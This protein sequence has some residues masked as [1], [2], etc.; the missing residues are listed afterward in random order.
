M[1]VEPDALAYGQVELGF[2]FTKRIL[3]FNDGDAPLNVNVADNRGA[4]AA[5]VSNLAQWPSRESGNSVI[6]P[7]PASGTS[8]RE[9]KMAYRPSTPGAHSIGMRVTGDDPANS[10]QSVSLTGEGIPPI[11]IDSVPVLDR[12]GSMGQFSGPHRKIDALQRAS[13]MFV[14]LPPDLLAHAADASSPAKRPS[15]SPGTKR[16]AGAGRLAQERC[17]RNQKLVGLKV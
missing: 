6:P 10:P 14:H 8:S 2:A 16:C 15:S 1:R 4:D 13:H 3:V 7:K 5:C 12:S 9:F 17:L 11:P